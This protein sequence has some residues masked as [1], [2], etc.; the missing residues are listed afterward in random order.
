[1]NSRFSKTITSLLLVAALAFS[2]ISYQGKK[3]KAADNYT[4]LFSINN[5]KD[6]DVVLPAGQ[7]VTQNFNVSSNGTINILVYTL[8]KTAMTLKVTSSTGTDLYNKT[9]LSSDSNWFEYQY[10][11]EVTLYYNGISWERPTS[12]SYT[13]TLI[14]EEDMYY[15]VSATQGPAV[16]IATQPPAPTLT[17]SLNAPSTGVITL[18]AGFTQTVSV[19]NAGGAV[20]WSSSNNSVATVNNNGNIT[21]KKA[22]S[23]TITARTAGGYTMTCQVKVVKN[24]FKRSKAKISNARVGEAVFSFHNISYDKKGNLI[25]KAR[26]LN[27]T[28]LRI[29]SLR[30]VKFKIKDNN[31][32]VIGTYSAKNIKKVNLNTGKIKAYT[33]KI[34]KSKLKNKKANLPMISDIVTS[35]EY[36]YRQRR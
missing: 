14:F 3:A 9:I 15:M 28:G 1:M 33:F 8:A 27:N 21:G 16:Q 13:L 25:I 30:K 19:N 32:K 22:G 35:G 26:L 20:T 10:S 6:T 12:G 23:A 4:T 11:P 29:L 17:P 5:L 24:V 31:G 2:G 18:T 34:K 36:V 7:A